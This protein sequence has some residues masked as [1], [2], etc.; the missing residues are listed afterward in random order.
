MAPIIS[1][2]L[3]TQGNGY[4]YRIDSF[5]ERRSQNIQSISLDPPVTTRNVL[6]PTMSPFER[7]GDRMAMVGLN[8]RPSLSTEDMGGLNDLGETMAYA[9][10]GRSVESFPRKNRQG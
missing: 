7:R 6:P 10:A 1:G 9:E 3:H 4:S 5:R 8:L 2:P